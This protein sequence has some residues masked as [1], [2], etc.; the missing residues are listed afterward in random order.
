MADG[1]SK[2]SMVHLAAGHRNTLLLDS[3]PLVVPPPPTPVK[4]AGPP[5]LPGPGGGGGGSGA[6]NG[7]GANG[8]GANGT[9][10]GAGGGG[11]ASG[12]GGK[13]GGLVD[14][15]AEQPGGGGGGAAGAAGRGRKG[16]GGGGGGGMVDPLA[17]APGGNS[18]DMESPGGGGGGGGG[19]RG[20]DVEPGKLYISHKWSVNSQ[21]WIQRWIAQFDRSGLSYMQSD[22]GSDAYI[23]ALEYHIARCEYVVLLITREYAVAMHGHQTRQ[24]K[25]VKWAMK[26]RCRI[27]PVLH[28]DMVGSNPFYEPPGSHVAKSGSALSE[29]EK[30]FL[31]HS[32][33]PLQQY[34][35]K[36]LH[37]VYYTKLLSR[38]GR[39]S[40][41]YDITQVK[42]LLE[43]AGLSRAFELL[44]LGKQYGGAGV[45][46][47]SDLKKLFSDTHH[48]VEPGGTSTAG[49]W[50]FKLQLSAAEEARLRTTMSSWHSLS[51]MPHWMRHGELSVALALAGALDEQILARFGVLDLSSL[52]SAGSMGEGGGMTVARFVGEYAGLWARDAP[53]ST[54]P[55]P[56][57][58]SGSTAGGGGPQ[59]PTGVFLTHLVLQSCAIGSKGAVA[60]LDSLCAGKVQLQVLD[61]ARNGLD[62]QAIPT[63]VKF[64]R[65]CLT[66]ESLC[67]AENPVGDLSGTS[68]LQCLGRYPGRLW[69]LDLAKSNVGGQ[70]VKALAL[71]IKNC[72]TLRKVNLAGNGLSGRVLGTLAAALYEGGVQHLDV[73]DN[74]VGIDFAIALS[75]AATSATNAVIA[76]AAAA[77]ADGTAGDGGLGAGAFAA[78]GGPPTTTTLTVGPGGVPQLVQI[79]NP[80]FMSM[81]GSRMLSRQLSR[82][83]DLNGGEPTP[84]A[85]GPATLVLAD[86]NMGA[87]GM[88]MLC[89]A[90][91]QCSGLT[92]LTLTRNALGQEGVSALGLMLASCGTNTL[93]SLQ[94]LDLSGNYLPAEGVSTLASSLRRLPQ[95]KVLS[96]EACGL[97]APQVAAVCEAVRVS[98]RVLDLLGKVLLGIINPQSSVQ[99]VG[100]LPGQGPSEVMLG[101]QDS[102]LDMLAA[103]GGRFSVA[104]IDSYGGVEAVCGLPQGTA[105]R[106]LPD[107]PS[108]L[109]RWM[110]QHSPL[111]GV[112]LAGL[113]AI[114]CAKEGD[115]RGMQ[116]FQQQLQELRG[117]GCKLRALNLAQNT[118]PAEAG[119]A[120]AV[121][122]SFNSTLQDLQLRGAA[123]DRSTWRSFE[124]WHKV[125]KGFQEALPCAPVLSSLDVTAAGITDACAAGFRRMLECSASLR[126]L[127]L[128][129]CRLNQAAMQVLAPALTTQPQLLSLSLDNCCDEQQAMAAAVH[130]LGGNLRL[131]RMSFRLNFLDGTIGKAMAAAVAKHPNLISLAL[132]GAM[133]YK[134]GDDGAVALGRALRGSLRLTHVNMS[135]VGLADG[136]GVTALA[137][138]L[139]A[140]PRLREVDLSGNSLGAHGAQ[141][142]V[143]ALQQRTVRLQRLG[144]EGNVKVPAHLARAAINLCTPAVSNKSDPNAVGGGLGS[145]PAPQDWGPFVP[146]GDSSSVAAAAVASLNPAAL[147]LRSKSSTG[148]QALLSP[149]FLN[150][151]ASMRLRGLPGG[152]GGMDGEASGMLTAQASVARPPLT[153]HSSMRRDGGG[154]MDSGG[155]SMMMMMAPGSA[156]ATPRGGLGAAARRPGSTPRGRSGLAASPRRTPRGG[157]GTPGGG[158]SLVPSGSVPYESLD[159]EVGQAMGGGDPD[160]YVIPE[161]AAVAPGGGRGGA[162]RGRGGRKAGG[163]GGGLDDP[164]GDDDAANMML[165]MRQGDGMTSP[166]QRRRLA[167]QAAAAAAAANQGYGPGPYSGGGGGSGG[168]IMDMVPDPA[169]PLPGLPGAA[170]GAPGAAAAVARRHAPPQKWASERVER[171]GSV[172]AVMMGGTGGGSGNGM[173]AASPDPRSPRTTGGAAGVVY[174]HPP[175]ARHSL[176]N[177]T[178]DGMPCSPSQSGQQSYL[179]PRTSIIAGVTEGGGMSPGAGGAMSGGGGEGMSPRPRSAVTGTSPARGISGNKPRWS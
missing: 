29:S 133:R 138:A 70:T 3:G 56:G 152:G 170:G 120:V 19:G 166:V 61:L 162:S 87:D 176:R 131:N 83:T 96:L 28:K 5:A 69:D 24:H 1:G 175:S 106:V 17:E 41:N 2:K 111:R 91:R 122:L 21:E 60:L 99:Q 34:V 4:V 73:S 36:E 141:Q 164:M 76:A 100:A 173:A 90:L 63:L 31:A 16:A 112:L 123:C 116:R 163:A 58:S 157:G 113:E 172:P 79:S 102:L 158:G 59:P 45:Q 57:A 43:L 160:D 114:S 139:G 110:M 71:A 93:S 140:N 25:E 108:M 118:L 39:K 53:R 13:K 167:A 10:S 130:V 124:M 95:L 178:G 126:H 125:I 105:M 42:E 128:D 8:G 30:H 82:A 169:A 98:D 179:S 54:S 27:V 6:A 149:R 55:A 146:I 151:G 15:L 119:T 37:D 78:A 48:A 142:L 89:A 22:M 74:P 18:M 127:R 174:P 135:C 67:L 88:Q 103:R 155:G 94:S 81:P 64:L 143:A 77:A 171:V 65:T 148:L 66:L 52:G 12:P 23:D 156:P 150:G 80:A 46:T 137:T 136:H 101:L 117:N 86:T 7:D 38:L 9:S 35:E 47:V 177:F 62:H 84:V 92:G 72:K 40:K 134:I 147:M 144:L 161:D 33:R 97:D 109:L 107:T 85:P 165:L 168:R 129:R 121:M 11:G 32:C 20:I 14:P 115:R 145:G 49:L 68:L 153:A 51:C 104:N 132:G 159:E 50:S 154:G 44:T 75:A 26:H